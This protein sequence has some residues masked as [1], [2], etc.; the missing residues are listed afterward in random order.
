[1]AQRQRLRLWSAVVLAV[2]LI[3]AVALWLRGTLPHGSGQ[4]ALPTPVS[5]LPTPIPA[6]GVAP[7]PSWVTGGAVLLWVALGIVVAL[8]IAFVI[9]HRH[10]HETR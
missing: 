3:I 1:M 8:G 6:S 4:S 7:V 9:L 2:L 10:S 5:P